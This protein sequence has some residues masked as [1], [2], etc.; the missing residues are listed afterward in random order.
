MSRRLAVFLVGG[1]GGGIGM[2]GV[3]AIAAVTAALAQRFDVTVHSL[4]H[5]HPA[6]APPGYR[7][8]SAPPWM[9]ARGVRKL[10]WLALARR[11]LADARR[12]PYDV[13]LSFWGYPMGP[14]VV[15]L[16]ALA[17]KPSVVAILGA[18]AASVP[19][20]GYGHLRRPA[21]RRLVLEACERASRVVVLSDYQRQMLQR[22]GLHR[23]DLDIVPFGVDAAM[24]GFQSRHREPPLKLVHVANLTPIKDQATLLR[25]FALL[26]RRMP[27]KLRIVGPDHMSGRVHALVAELGVGADVELAGP[28]PYRDIARHYHW[29][30]A[31]LL[32]SLY[33]GQSTALTEAAMTGALLVSTPVGYA[34]DIGPRGAVLVRPGDPADLAEKIRAMAQDD[35]EWERKVAFAR[36][37]AES[38][39]LGFTVRRYESIIEDACRWTS[40]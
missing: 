38:R 15:A 12:R 24:F 25:G 17:R 28:V 5:P 34:H 33:E 27:A 32:T 13:L 19:S 18:E 20:I 9:G 8:R 11:F 40:A 29:A 14:F 7:V 37:W 26:R 36:A 2:Q 39:D 22:H 10:R 16:A 23:S 1:L 4:V 30:D 3:P 31:F 21:T 6:F 35:A